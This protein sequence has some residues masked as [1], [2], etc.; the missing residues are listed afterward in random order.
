MDRNGTAIFY[1][2]LLGSLAFFKSFYLISLLNAKTD[3]CHELYFFQIKCIEVG[4]FEICYVGLSGDFF[5][6]VLHLNLK[7][8]FIEKVNAKN[9]L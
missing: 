5:W 6:R 1:L 4:L 8:Q 7:S 2:F 3:S 9:N